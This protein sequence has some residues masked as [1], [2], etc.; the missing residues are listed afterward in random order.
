[1][2]RNNLELTLN[3]YVSTIQI[4]KLR[5][6]TKQ[7]IEKNQKRGASKFFFLYLIK[8]RISLNNTPG[9]P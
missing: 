6:I 9:L 5:G 3:L 2:E 1:M 4:K 7:P 8:R